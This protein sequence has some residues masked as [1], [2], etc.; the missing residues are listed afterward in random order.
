M[1]TIRRVFCALVAVGFL[2]VA[3]AAGAVEQTGIADQSAAMFASSYFQPLN[4]PISRLVVSYDAVLRGT[5]EV[6]D[7]DAWLYSARVSGIEPLIAFNHARGCY[8]GKGVVRKVRCRLPSVQRFQRAFE[9]FRSRYPFV[10]VYSPWN[11]A[12]H[13]SQPTQRRPGRAAAFYNLVRRGCPSCT[14]VAVD[15]LDIRGM[16]DYVRTFRRHA[17][18][19]PRIWGLHNYHDANDGGSSATRE[20]LRTV[21]GEVWLT[22]TG[23]IVKLGKRRPFDPRRAKSATKHMFAVAQVS[24]RITRMYIYNWTGGGPRFDSGLTT[25][26]GRPRPAYYVVRSHLGFK[27]VPP[28]PPP[29]PGPPPP[30]PACLLLPALCP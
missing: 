24:P 17:D 4:V 25:R 13:V 30:P 26:A 2:A 20:L 11:E 28:P 23:G 3:P 1:R 14:V 5:Y 18:G 12:N 29:A 16:A 6:A 21:T 27:P 7:I 8:D 22:E 9:S 19:T 10:T 15:V